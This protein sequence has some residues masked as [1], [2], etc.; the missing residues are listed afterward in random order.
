MTGFDDIRDPVS[1]TRQAART[2]GESN[3]AHAPRAH[4][5]PGERHRTTSSLCDPP[6]PQIHPHPLWA[7]HPSVSL[8]RRAPSFPCTGYR[9]HHF[10]YNNVNSTTTN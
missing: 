1:M 8:G 7:T 2:G 4:R 9:P 10:P 5:N 6:L 3:S